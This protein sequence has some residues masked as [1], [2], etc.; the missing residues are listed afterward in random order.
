MYYYFLILLLI[1]IY[2]PFNIPTTEIWLKGAVLL[3]VMFL[4]LVLC[5]DVMSYRQTYKIQKIK[6]T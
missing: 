5:N 1:Y 4:L 6:N 2:F 3:G